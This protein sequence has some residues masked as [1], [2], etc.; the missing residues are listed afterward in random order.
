MEEV[1][2]VVDQ[3]NPSDAKCI[4]K[5]RDLMQDEDMLNDLTFIKSYLGF[6]SNAITKLEEQGLSLHHSLAILEEAQENLGSI[7]GSR[8]LVFLN[9]LKDV[10]AK[11]ETL[12][13]LIH[14]DKVLSGEADSRIPP[15]FT[16]SPL[17]QV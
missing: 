2:L 7:P 10:V 12:Q 11:N 3:F 17:P 1:K 5:R 6:L 16:P 13:A 14:I 8:G 15:D 9:R 4:R